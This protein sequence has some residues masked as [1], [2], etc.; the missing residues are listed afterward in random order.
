[1][2]VKNVYILYP[3]GYS[4]S[5]INWAINI[6][7]VDLHTDTVKDP[8]N[9]AESVTFGGAGTTHHHVRIPTHQSYDSHI[10]WVLYNRPTTPKIYIINSVN[11]AEYEIASI[12]NHDPT[13]VFIR[14]HNNNDKLINSYGLINCV[15]KWPTYFAAKAAFRRKQL[16]YD[17]FD[18]SKDQ[19]AR[20]VFFDT[21]LLGSTAMSGP[22]LDYTVLETHLAESAEWFHQRN[23]YQPHEVNKSTY[24]TDISIT[25]RIFELSCLDVASQE[26]LNI[27]ENIMIQSQVSDNFDLAYVKQFHNNYIKAQANLQWFDSI[28]KWK[29][30]GDLDDYLI[31]HSIIEACVI[32]EMY[33]NL[34]LDDITEWPNFYSNVKDPSWPDCN[35]EWD[36]DSLPELIQDELINVFNYVPKPSLQSTILESTLELHNTWR[37]KSIQEING[38][39]Q[40]IIKHIG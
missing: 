39:Y 17:P 7:D 28:N 18:C 16:T 27:F 3:P 38:M 37:S 35:N 9:Q 5:Y 36:F 11:S 19:V 20:A 40:K 29:Q 23:K 30:S 33:R 8:L 6:S 2:L 4:G 24:I 26:F 10:N 13:G 22:T 32:R 34:K 1:M 14:I 12:L 31:S 25:N 21:Q 15:I